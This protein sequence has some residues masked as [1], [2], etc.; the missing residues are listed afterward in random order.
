M[1]DGDSEMLLVGVIAHHESVAIAENDVVLWATHL[2]MLRA[3]VAVHYDAPHVLPSAIA[4]HM[5]P[6]KRL[7]W[8]TVRGHHAIRKRDSR[9]AWDMPGTPKRG[10]QLV[11]RWRRHDH[12]HAIC[13]I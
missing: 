3:K 9:Q 13:G 11:S 2:E 6:K 12:I 4:L 1:L 7:T 10:H 5:P 8:L